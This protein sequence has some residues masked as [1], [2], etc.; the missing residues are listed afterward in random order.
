VDAYQEQKHVYRAVVAAVGVGDLAALDV[1]L[2]PDLTD[3]NPM[4]DQAC[5]PASRWV[6]ADRRHTL[7]P[8]GTDRWKAGTDRWKAL[9][10][11][12]AAVE[13]EFG[14]L[15][16]NWALA[17][18]RVRRIERVRLHADLTI[19]SRLA[20]AL[21]TARAVPLAAEPPTPRSPPTAGNFGMPQ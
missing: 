19:L 18:P 16:H 1:L 13:R 11:Q 9:Y 8:R 15:K 5:R 21:A 14:N 3:H 10:R 17:P 12:R 2:A 7:V 6:K 20:C 4:P